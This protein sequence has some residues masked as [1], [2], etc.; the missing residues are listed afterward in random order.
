MSIFNYI[1]QAQGLRCHSP[2]KPNLH[3]SF[4]FFEIYHSISK[5]H[6]SHRVYTY[7]WEGCRTFNTLCERDKFLNMQW[8]IMKTFFLFTAK[9]FFHHD[10]ILNLIWTLLSLCITAHKL[11]RTA[12]WAIKQWF[13]FY[14][15][16]KRVF[17]SAGHQTYYFYNMAVTNLFIILEE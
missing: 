8:V 16:K 2:S 9:H 15:L 6:T 12:L 10:L 11:I 17:Q 14:S 5:I 4:L 1:L 3:S 13:T 7:I